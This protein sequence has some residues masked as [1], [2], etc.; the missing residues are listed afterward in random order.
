M[1]NINVANT[2]STKSEFRAAMARER[3]RRSELVSL[4]SGLVARLVRPTPGEM[5]MRTGRLPQS[6]AARLSGGANEAAAGEELI[7]LAKQ[8]VELCRFVFVEPRVPDELEPG[9][10]VSYDDIEFALRWARGEVGNAGPDLAS[11]RGGQS[12]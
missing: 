9:V 8:T 2:P 1:E 11:F 6:V 4:P 5:F 10:D 7:A 12:G 3:E